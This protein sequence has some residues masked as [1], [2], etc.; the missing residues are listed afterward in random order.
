MAGYQD[1]ENQLW[2]QLFKKKLEKDNIKSHIIPLDSWLKKKPDRIEGSGVLERYKTEKIKNFISE[3]S[4]DDF[5]EI[6]IPDFCFYSKKSTASKKILIKKND[7]II[8]EGIP[9]LL[10]DDL[11]KLSN[12]KFYVDIEKGLRHNRI[13]TEYKSRLYKLEKIDS[14]IQSRKI[15]E[16]VIIK[17]SNKH[18]NFI[19][20]TYDS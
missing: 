18:A 12:L 7:K 15:D 11:L 13:R 19:I 3:I 10:F 16:D 5:F 20:K 1:Q 2:P 17:Q 8:I 6:N 4:L 9:A 14:I